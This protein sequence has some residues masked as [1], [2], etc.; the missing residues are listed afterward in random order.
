MLLTLV[1]KNTSFSLTTVI[2][3]NFPKRT[4]AQRLKK[5]IKYIEKIFIKFVRT[6]FKNF[7]YKVY[8]SFKV[9]KR[10]TWVQNVFNF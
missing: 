8:I 9:L 1:F 5:K 6:A 7:I 4:T 2:K 3:L 10:F